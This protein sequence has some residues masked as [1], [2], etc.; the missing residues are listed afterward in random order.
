MTQANLLIDALDRISACRDDSARWAAGV[1]LLKRSGSA[2]LTAGTAPRDRPVSVAVRTTTPATLMD[3]YIGSGLHRQDTWMQHCAVSTE[4]DT[5]VVRPTAWNQAPRTQ[6]AIPVA[7]LFD[8]HGVHL[9]ILM[10][11]YGGARPGGF[12]LYAL[13]ADEADWLARPAGMA[14][15]RLLTAIVASRYRPDED[16]SSVSQRYDILSPLTPRE[17]EVLQWLSLGLQTARIA[18]RMGIASV[19][20]SKHLAACC[21]KLDART[22]ERALAIALRDRL[23]AI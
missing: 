16:R 10:P 11:T 5:C 7:R 1:D 14:Q 4:V 23:I 2:W 15:A 8:D 17:A 20:V 21:R 12:V 6:A 3:D 13:S 19:T 22:R 9:A 18:E